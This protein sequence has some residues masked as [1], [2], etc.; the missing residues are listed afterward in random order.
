MIQAEQATPLQILTIDRITGM[1]DL[2]IA[3]QSK[4]GMGADI[5][6]DLCACTKAILAHDRLRE[7]VADRLAA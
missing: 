2:N 5:R 6:G 3:P 7:F 4:D 1:F